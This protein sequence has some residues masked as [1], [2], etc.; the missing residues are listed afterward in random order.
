MAVGD[1]VDPLGQFNFVI[2][3]DGIAAAGFSESSGLTTETSPIEYREGNEVPTV[4]KLPGLIVY[5]NIMLKR[6]YTL[7]TEL[8]EWRK[9]T[10]DGR[11]E[12][13]DGAIILLNEAREPIL[14]WEFRN[15][16]VSKYEGPT[17]NSTANE[18]AIESIE[19]VHEGLELVS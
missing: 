5:S 3:I 4:R 17:L 12:R 13:K 8:W 15:G 10:E 19:I 1:R 18:T 7:N 16:W 14:R 2:E 9:T 11:T 6:G